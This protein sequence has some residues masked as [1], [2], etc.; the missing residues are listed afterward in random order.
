[1]NQPTLLLVEDD[2]DL[3]NVMCQYLETQSFS[4]TLCRDGKAGLQA[5]KKGINAS[6]RPFDL[7]VLDVM[8]PKMDGFTLAKKM[9]RFQGEIPFLFLTAKDQKQDRLK[10]LGLGA[11]DY[12]TKP[13]EIDELVLRIQNI[14]RR[15]SAFSTSKQN[16]YRIG[17]MSFESENLLLRS[18][19][20]D[21]RLTLQ[22]S[23][24]LQYFIEHPNKILKRQEILQSIWGDDD[25]FNGRSM[26]VFIS[27]LRKY[28]KE[29]ISVQIETIRGV[30]YR[31]NFSPTV[32]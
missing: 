10:G 20:Q 29:E 17:E 18:K 26:D 15:T 32:K 14:L 16:I 4:V 22:E 28:L 24:L 30:G 13:F 19:A 6:G 2:H 8:L 23:K 7:C 31:F 12:I 1:M 5:F 27:R 9:S 11:D 21:R 25:Y 3:G